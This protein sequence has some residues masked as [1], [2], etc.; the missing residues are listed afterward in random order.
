MGDSM[1]TLARLFLCLAQKKERPEYSGR[2]RLAVPQEMMPT[3]PA[4]IKTLPDSGV[5][6]LPS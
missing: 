6:P 1:Q 5:N 4:R 3:N 2:S